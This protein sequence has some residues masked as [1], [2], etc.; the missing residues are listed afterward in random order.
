MHGR[1][2]WNN[3]PRGRTWALAALLLFLPAV[4]FPLLTGAQEPAPVARITEYAIP[5]G[6]FPH[7]PALDPADIVYYT[8]QRGNKIGRLNPADGQVTEFTVPTANSG[9]HGL[10]SDAAGNIWFTE[11]SAG[12]IG[13]LDPRTGQVTEFPMP[14][15]TAR[16]PHT[17]IFDQRGILWFTVQGANRVGRLDPATGEV[18]L[19]A[20]PTARALPYGIKVD[21]SGVPWFV[22]FGT[23]K[24]ARI[25]PATFEIQEFVIPEG[26]ARPRRLAIAPN[27]DIY[28][29]DFNVGRLGRFRPATAEFRLWDSPSGRNSQPYGIAADAFGIIWYNESS[30]SRIVRFDPRDE[31]F[32]TV[33]IP[34]P[35]SVVRHMEVDS[36]GRVWLAESGIDR[37][38]KVEP[39]PRV[40]PAGIVNAA[41]FSGSQL[42]PGEI[43]SIFGTNLAFATVQAAELPLPRELAGVSLTLGDIPLPLFYVSPGQINAQVPYEAPLGSPTLAVKQDRTNPQGGMMIAFGLTV[44]VAATAPGIFVAADGVTALAVDAQSGRLINAENPAAGGSVVT[45]FASGLGAVNPPVASGAAGALQEPFNRTTQAISVTV[46]DRAAEVLFSGVAPGYAGLYQLNVRLPSPLP[47]GAAAVVLTAAGASSKPANLSIR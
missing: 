8:A 30:V 29:T 24:L 6:S 44:T 32:S 31:S 41:G 27:A 40:V 35:G 14:D 21:A 23:N 22:E 7:D 33:T 37:I 20:V 5:A 47:T 10:V 39:L 38:G 3:T 26:N 17:P 15:S 12:K 43:I 45:L 1:F 36:V 19:F 46:G 18:R 42:A 4:L 16:D 25:D 13:K 28:F 11:N 2:S 9:P 34:T